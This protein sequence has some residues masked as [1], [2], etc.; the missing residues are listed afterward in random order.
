M[1]AAMTGGAL[2]TGEQEQRLEAFLAVDRAQSFTL[3]RAPLMRLTLIRMAEDVYQLVWTLPPL[4]PGWVVSA[5]APAKTSFSAMTPFV[6]AMRCILTCAGHTGTTL[7]GCNSRTWRRLRHSGGRPCRGFTTPTAL[8][9][10]SVGSTV[11]NQ[12][13][14]YDEQRQHLSEALT[15]ALQTLAR[16]HH[17]SLN[18]LVQGA[19]AVLLSRYSGEEDVIFGAGG[20]RSPSS[21]GGGG[22]DD[23]ALYEHSTRTGAGVA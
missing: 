18:S 8:S 3:S 16:Q 14:D 15:D 10:G 13:A 2:S 9:R 22:V 20:L 7:P 23:R 4:A 21:P 17:L 11:T 19:W 6:P 5:C 12:A 1:A